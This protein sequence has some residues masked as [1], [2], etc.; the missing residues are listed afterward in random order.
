MLIARADE[1]SW[2]GELAQSLRPLPID[3]HWSR[4]ERQALDLAMNAGIHVAVVDG[5]FA[6][7]GALGLLRQFRQVGLAAPCLLVCEEPSPRLLREALE[8]D[9]FSV[10]SAG[11]V[12]LLRPTVIKA[13]QRVHPWE[14]ASADGAN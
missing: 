5:G 11:D 4:D 12:H 9:A 2:A 7:C 3:V 13:L 6:S 1:G 8:L 14:W 10:F